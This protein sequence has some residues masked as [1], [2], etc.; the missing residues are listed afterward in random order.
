MLDYK[1]TNRISIKSESGQNR[2]TDIIY[3]IEKN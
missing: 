1:W 2:S 3:S